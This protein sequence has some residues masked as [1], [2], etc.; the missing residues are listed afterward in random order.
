MIRNYNLVTSCLSVVTRHS[1]VVYKQCRTS[2]W[3]QYLALDFVGPHEERKP[4]NPI[5]WEELFVDRM[6]LV[7]YP[8]KPIQDDC[9]AS[10]TKVTFLLLSHFFLY[11]R[12]LSFETIVCHFCWPPQAQFHNLYIYI[13]VCIY[14]H[15][16]IKK[17]FLDF[18]ATFLPATDRYCGCQTFKLR[19]IVKLLYTVIYMVTHIF[20][21]FCLT[22]RIYHPNQ[23]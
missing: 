7:I 8:E 12:I 15:Q 20:F 18:F 17:F 19:R 1:P 11:Y 10:K 4:D 6:L 5:W 16:C 9:S 13:Y 23:L 14:M 21:K 3:W 2:E 22:F